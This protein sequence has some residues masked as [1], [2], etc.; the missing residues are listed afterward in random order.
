MKT[1]RRF[2]AACSS[3]ISVQCT[4]VSIVPHG[5]LHDQLHADGGGEVID[6]VRVIDQLGDEASIVARADGPMR[7]TA[8]SRDAGRS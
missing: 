6:E 2:L 8:M 5:T 4:F 3:T 7:T 1:G